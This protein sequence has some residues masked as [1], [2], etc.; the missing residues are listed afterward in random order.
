MQ[1]GA[2]TIRRCRLD[3]AAGILDDNCVVPSAPDWLKLL[4]P[5]PPGV[6]PERKP[7]ASAALLANGTAGPIA[8]WESISVHLSDEIGSRHVLI[9][10]D[11]H[12]RL[13]SAGDHVTRIRDSGRD[14]SI[15]ISDHES[16]G[17]R[18]DESGFLGTRWANRIECHDGQ[19]EGTMT[20]AVKSPPTA[21][22]VALLR[23]LVD[24]LLGRV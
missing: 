16:I 12:G 10:I 22:E 18:F 11:E 9:T 6:K 21:D 2:P 15:T 14:G 8:G 13:L 20:S 1:T 23:A 19:D 7:V 4:V 3:R 5:I 17:G 24:D